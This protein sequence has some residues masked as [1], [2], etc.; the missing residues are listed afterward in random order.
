MGSPAEDSGPRI[1]SPRSSTTAA[2]PGHPFRGVSVHFLATEFL[3]EMKG[4]GQER[5]A[6][7]FEVEPTVIRPRGVAT[8]CPRETTGKLGAAYVDCLSGE[9]NVGL[10][11]H[12]LSYSWGYEVGDIVDTLV[13]FCKRKGLD[14]KRTYVWVCCLC[15][16]QHRVK[17]A[18]T[19]GDIVPFSEFE[20]TFRNRVHGIGNVICMMAPWHDPHYLKRVWCIFEVYT[21]HK[22]QLKCEIAMPPKETENLVHSICCGGLDLIWGAIKGVMVEKAEASVEDDRQNILALI[23]QTSSHRL[24]NMEVCALFRTWFSDMGDTLIEEI[25]EGFRAKPEMSKCFG[26]LSRQLSSLYLQLGQFDKALQLSMRAITLRT[27]HGA[28]STL[29]GALIHHNIANIV[30]EQ[31]RDSQAALKHL[32]LAQAIHQSVGPSL[33]G[34][35]TDA[36]IA[37]RRYEEGDICAQDFCEFV[38]TTHDMFKSTDGAMD[39]NEYAALL[40]IM[41]TAQMMEGHV[42]EALAHFEEA[43]QIRTNHGGME[44][45]FGTRLLLCL[46]QARVQAGHLDGVCDSLSKVRDQVDR[47]G[48]QSA[49][50]VGL[51]LVEGLVFLKCGRLRCALRRLD[52]ALGLSDRCV[53]HHSIV[54]LLRGMLADALDGDDATASGRHCGKLLPDGQFSAAR[55]HPWTATSLRTLAHA[56]ADAP[57]SAREALEMARELHRFAGTLKS[58]E[59][60][61]VCE[62]IAQISKAEGGRCSTGVLASVAVGVAAAAASLS[63]VRGN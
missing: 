55:R 21:A 31:T 5:S 51:C 28:M 18:Q 32:Y 24:L 25:I 10:S 62:A 52:D 30:H 4:L 53:R 58:S 47:F 27:Q 1:D 49:D 45:V 37:M 6:K 57:C 39:T 50:G 59:G 23:E 61:A 48:L 41:A 12:M 54:S 56:L 40:Q 42:P 22:G 60:L 16:N 14:A 26:H 34:S 20:A 15:V 2:P 46:C 8:R 19:R 44:T 17:E 35:F 29:E 11:T 9:D 36:I 43:V 33:D 63:F 38:R 3:E 7:V 13:A